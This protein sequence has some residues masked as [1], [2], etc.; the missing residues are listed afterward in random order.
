MKTLIIS[1]KFTVI[2]CI[3]LFVGY[4]LVLWGFSAAV[5]PNHGEAEV[6]TLKDQVVGAIN[7]G[8]QFTKNTYFWG[9]PSAVD[10]DG[11]G[12]GGSNKAASNKEYLQEVETRMTTFLEA[13]PYLE[14][15]D[16]PSELVTASGSGL[17]PHISPAAAE[18]QVRRVAEARG[19]AAATVQ[20]IVV[21]NIHKPLIGQPY[22][23]VL[24]LNVALD[25]NG[26]N[27][28]SYF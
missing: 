5:K 8:Q 13:H 1:I 19:L 14:R 28:L 11:G 22:V 16:V 3:L 27:N 17:D 12:S 6:I 20:R 2:L 23:N 7:V 21:E 4:V 18:I 25:N 26:T 10:Y 15:K 9:R 24:E